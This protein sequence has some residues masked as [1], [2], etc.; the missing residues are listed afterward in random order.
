[1]NAE[2]D[3]VQWRPTFVIEVQSACCQQKF[4]AG[5]SESANMNHSSIIKNEAR[6]SRFESI[7]NP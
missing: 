4:K 6:K 5:G 1:M 2:F 7:V 3:R